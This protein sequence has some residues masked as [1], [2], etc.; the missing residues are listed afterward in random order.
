MR[1]FGG[2]YVVTLMRKMSDFVFTLMRR[3]RGV[4]MVT[5]MRRL[6][7]VFIV[8]LRRLGGVY[9]DILRRRL[10][11][12]FM[13]TFMRTVCDVFGLSNEGAMRRLYSHCYEESTRRPYGHLCGGYE[14]SLWSPL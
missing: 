14:S 4:Y 7:D 10:R 12:V 8:T 11:E 6:G 5:L 13:V 2:V 3:L 9:M 1:R